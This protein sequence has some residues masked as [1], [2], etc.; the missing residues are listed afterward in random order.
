MLRKKLKSL[1]WIFEFKDRNCSLCYIFH[2]FFIQITYKD[3]KS[4]TFIAWALQGKIK[5]PWQRGERKVFK[6]AEYLLPL[7]IWLLFKSQPGRKL[8]FLRRNLSKFPWFQKQAIDSIK[9]EILSD[10]AVIQKFMTGTENTRQVYSRKLKTKVIYVA[11]PG[12][13][14]KISS[15]SYLCSG[16]CQ[17]LDDNSSVEKTNYCSFKWSTQEAELVHKKET[18]S[19]HVKYLVTSWSIDRGHLF[20]L[21]IMMAC[22]LQK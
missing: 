17:G 8:P 5:A 4:T 10:F 6:N 22:K 21:A 3:C 13:S 19:I 1:L 11:F 14:Q 15:F 16:I 2:V 12:L 7:L 9:H 20:H 18:D